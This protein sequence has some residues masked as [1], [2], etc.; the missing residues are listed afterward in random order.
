MGE[1]PRLRVAVLTFSVHLPSKVTM[2]EL[3]ALAMAIVLG[4]FQLVACFGNCEL[5][6]VVAA[7]EVMLHIAHCGVLPIVMQE[8]DHQVVFRVLYPSDSSAAAGS[9]PSSASPAAP[10][11]SYADIEAD[12]LAEFQWHATLRISDEFISF[13]PCRCKP[14]RQ[15]DGTLLIVGSKAKPR[16]GLWASPVAGRP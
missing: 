2:E 4:G 9:K 3:E 12:L 11:V 16:R 8:E 7:S 14:W 1:P 6:V 10:R 13:T 15:T 5:S